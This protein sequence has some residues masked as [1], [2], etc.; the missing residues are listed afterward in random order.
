MDDDLPPFSE[1]RLLMSMFTS[2]AREK[3]TRLDKIGGVVVGI[4]ELVK[5]GVQAIKDRRK[6]RRAED[7]FGETLGVERVREHGQMSVG[8]PEREDV[9]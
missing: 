9:P 1:R 2:R 5:L 8:H 6:P 3:L 7:I 4:V